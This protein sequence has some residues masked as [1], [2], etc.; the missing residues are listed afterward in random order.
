MARGLEGGVIIP[1]VKKGEG[2]VV[3]DYRE[4]GHAD[5]DDIQNICASVRG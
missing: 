3:E 4:R 1:I 5:V 2:K